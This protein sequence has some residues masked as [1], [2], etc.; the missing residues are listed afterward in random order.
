MGIACISRGWWLTTN[1]VDCFVHYRHS[2]P[3]QRNW[4]GTIGW[5]LRPNMGWNI[6]NGRISSQLMGGMGTHKWGQEQ[7]H[8]Q[9]DYQPHPVHQRETFDVLFER[10]DDPFEE[11]AWIH[12]SEVVARCFGGSCT[13]K[14]HCRGH[15]HCIPQILADS[16][17]R[18]VLSV[19]YKQG[20]GSGLLRMKEAPKTYQGVLDGEW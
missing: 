1:D 4:I 6:L 10:C 18:V 12:C 9:G 16:W 8:H 17:N 20:E 3:R 15:E 13:P 5:N 11:M 2:F 7:R 14:N 19:Q